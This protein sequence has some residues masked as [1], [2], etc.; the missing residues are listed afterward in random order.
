M[1]TRPKQV[2]SKDSE[3]LSGDKASAESIYLIEIPT[4][5]SINDIKPLSVGQGLC[6]YV[7]PLNKLSA[8]LCPHLRG[9]EKAFQGPPPCWCQLSRS[10]LKESNLS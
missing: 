6:S 10:L 9:E 4:G 7:T 1:A 8:N 3:A 5:H 2:F